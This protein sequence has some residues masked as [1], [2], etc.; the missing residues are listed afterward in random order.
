MPITGDWTAPFKW[1][2]RPET[3][4]PASPIVVVAADPL[5]EVPQAEIPGVLAEI[6]DRHWSVIR[7]LLVEAKLR[8]EM[9]LRNDEIIKNPALAS[10]YQGWVNYADYVLGSLEGLRSGEIQP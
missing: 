10:H 1:F 4:S 7:Q 2:Y 8:A 5:R 3:K 6:D 9:Q